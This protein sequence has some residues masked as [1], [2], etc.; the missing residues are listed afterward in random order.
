MNR[1]TYYHINFERRH[2]N[3]KVK[4]FNLMSQI[5]TDHQL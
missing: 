1:K 5:H 2:Y 3:C 4:T